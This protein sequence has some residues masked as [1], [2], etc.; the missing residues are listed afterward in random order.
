MSKVVVYRSWQRIAGMA[1]VPSMNA[2]QG[3]PAARV[4][5]ARRRLPD[6]RQVGQPCVAGVVEKTGQDQQCASA[7]VVHRIGSLS[8]CRSGL[9]E[10]AAPLLGVEAIRAARGGPG[11]D[12]APVSVRQRQ[13]IV[14]GLGRRFVEAD[15]RQ[16]TDVGLPSTRTERM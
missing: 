13:Q 5:E 11:D 14:H 10:P 3:D 4:G 1:A 7:V 16:A 8:D 6:P 2:M 9:L 12:E 15:F